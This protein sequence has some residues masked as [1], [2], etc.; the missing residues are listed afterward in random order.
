MAAYTRGHDHH[1]ARPHHGDHRPGRQLPR[2]ALARKGYEVVGLARRSSTVTF[3]RIAHIQER[4]TIETGDLLDQGSLIAALS[5]HR[6]HEVYNLAAQSYVAASFGQPVLT[7]D[8][9]GLGVH[10]AARGDPRRR[11]R[12]PAL[13]GV[14]VGDVRQRRCHAAT[15]GAHRSRRA[16]RTE[17]RRRMRT[18]WR[19]TTGS[20]T[21]CT[22]RAGSRS[23]TRAH[24]EGTSSSPAR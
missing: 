7:G 21:T 18:S 8:V 13:P 1:E 15:R 4:L 20:A 11:S 12:H 24:D 23:T 16:R 6:P 14:V 2:R 10:A 22:C 5:T 3:E 17:R 9:T 19:S